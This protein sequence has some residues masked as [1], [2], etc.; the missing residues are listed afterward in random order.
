MGEHAPVIATV[1][2]IANDP[3]TRLLS[4]L[5]KEWQGE[6]IGPD[7]PDWSAHLS[8]SL[9]GTGFLKLHGLSERLRTEIAWMVH[10]QYFD[11]VRISSGTFNRI[12][13]CMAWHSDRGRIPADSLVDMDLQTVYR[14]HATYFEATHGRLPGVHSTEPVR[15]AL[16]YPRLALIARLNAGP[17]WD[18]D[19]WLPR[20]DPRIPLREREPK[21]DNGCFI[22]ELDIPWLRGAAKWALGTMLESGSLSWSTVRSRAFSMQRFNRWL[23]TLEDPLLIFNLDHVSALAS[24]FMAW[25]EVPENRVLKRHPRVAR[26]RQ[27]NDDVSA[28]FRMMEFL[29][30]HREEARDYLGPNPWESL[31]HSHLGL[32]ERR[33]KQRRVPKGIKGEYYIDDHAVSQIMSCLPAIA[34]PLGE[35]VNVN[36]NGQVKKIN[37]QGDPQVMRMLLLQILTGRRGSEICLCEF[38]C[39]SAAAGSTTKAA[40]G[41]EVARFRYA[42]SKIDGAPDTILVD[43]EVVAIIKEQQQWVTERFPDG[44]RRYLFP[45][46]MANANG[47]KPLTLG[48]YSYSLK[49]FSLDAQIADK[50]G[51]LIELN[52]T[53]RFRHT[54]LT[55]LAELGLPIHVIQRYAGHSTPTMTMHYVAQREEHAEQ[56][57]LAT[58]K[59][60]ADG[61]AVAFSREDHDG[62]HLFNRADRFLP[63][64]YCLLPPLQTCDKGNACLTCSVFV[65]D[66]SHLDTLRRQLE[67]T[68]ALIDKQTEAFQVRHG[69]P[70]PEDNVWLVQRAAERD[71]LVRLLGSMQENPGRACQG[72]GSPTAGPTPVTIDMNRRRKAQP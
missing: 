69:R 52:Q 37:G 55:N 47:T 40:N 23:H 22:G 32:W 58:R 50:T 21:A 72:A 30:D 71:A 35:T 1:P 8:S 49:K 3:T 62:M 68:E 64:G 46:R 59:F 28:V 70:M 9:A 51:K 6:T 12:A 38:D 17:W 20:C 24:N 19:F 41:E 60:K 33:R 36:V 43:A 4:D 53:H 11:G 63:H 10:W 44:S 61:A 42:Q 56:A 39:L 65:T 31:T 25:L 66:P 15:R 54:K 27:A 29:I 13:R 48:A 26:T 57:F 16:G 7:I 5:P 2:S 34:A 45:A 18:L 14:L 67:E